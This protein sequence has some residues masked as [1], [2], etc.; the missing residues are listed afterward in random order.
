[1]KVGVKRAK[2]T[3]FVED[4]QT[5]VLAALEIAR[6]KIEAEMELVNRDGARTFEGGEYEKARD[7]LERAAKIKSLRDRIATIRD[8][9]EALFPVE[10]SEASTE[11][12]VKRPIRLPRGK[13]TP[14]DC[15]YRPILEALIDLGGSAPMSEVLE[16]VLQHMKNTLRDVDFKPLASTADMPRWRNTAA[17]ARNTLVERGLLRSDSPRGVWEISDSGTRFLRRGNSG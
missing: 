3:T 11:T 13:R 15:Y 2:E 12:T 9:W 4:N 14:E 6:E 1:M 7:A 16:C 5:N 17:W 10:A 8:E